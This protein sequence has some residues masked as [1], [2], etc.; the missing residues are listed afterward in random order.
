MPQ[1]PRRHPGWRRP[2]EQ[3]D[4]RRRQAVD[5]VDLR[6]QALLQA[7]DLGLAL[8]AYTITPH[9]PRHP[10]PPPPT[11]WPRRQSLHAPG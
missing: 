10:L 4:L 6:G 3:F 5:I 7:L 1:P 8:L 11:C 9:P 2:P